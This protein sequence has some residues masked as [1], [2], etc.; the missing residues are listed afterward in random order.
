[1]D[2]VVLSPPFPSPSINLIGAM[3]QTFEMTATLEHCGQVEVE[4]ATVTQPTLCK[5]KRKMERIIR[6]KHGDVLIL[7]M[8]HKC[9]S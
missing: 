9:V 5:A 3:M 8:E 4:K 7:S 6:K 1:M 2:G